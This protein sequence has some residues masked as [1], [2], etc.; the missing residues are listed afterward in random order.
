MPQ[1]VAK[2][3]EFCGKQPG[4]VDLRN[5]GLISGRDVR[6]REIR[7]LLG[8]G[9]RLRGVALRAVLRSSRCR[10]CCH[11]RWRRSWPRRS[12]SSARPT[13]SGGATSVTVVA[14]VAPVAFAQLLIQVVKIWPQALGSASQQLC[15]PLTLTTMVGGRRLREIHDRVRLGVGQVHIVAA[16]EVRHLRGRSRVVALSAAVLAADVVPQVDLE[17]LHVRRRGRRSRCRRR[18][19]WS[20]RRPAEPS[21]RR[22]RRRKRRGRVRPPE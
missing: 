1:V 17:G 8:G 10:S 22:R 5:R 20:E 21:C 4:E 14:D 13:A 15:P 18:R 12:S 11:S 9:I 19:C 7:R 16:R 6:I 2:V 3:A